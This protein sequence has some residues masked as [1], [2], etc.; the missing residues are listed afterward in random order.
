MSDF[1]PVGLALIGGVLPAL[2]WLWFWRHEDSN[3]PEPRR[4]IA[5]AFFAGMTTVAV[6]V[7]I[8]KAVAPFL[9]STTMLFAVWSAIEEVFKYLAARISVLWRKENDEPID[10]VIYMMAVALG[11]AALENALFLVAP[12]AG[13]SVVSS[14]MTGN[15]RFVG[16]T[17]LHVLSSGAI[18]IMLAISFYKP[19]RVK[20]YYAW[21]GVILAIILHGGFNFLILNTPEENLYRTFILVWIGLVVVLAVLEYIK[22]M[23]LPVQRNK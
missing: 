21:F 22:R 20:R 16:A 14:V 19:K 7:P 18:G 4:L 11:F 6:V 5:L 23:S 12:L 17:L 9:I 15:L 10:A 8:Q 13:H 1:L 2:A 3:H